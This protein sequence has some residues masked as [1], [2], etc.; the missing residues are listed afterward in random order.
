MSTSAEQ[1]PPFEEL[2][3]ED[4]VVADWRFDQFRSLGFGDEDASLLE[5][6]GAD[7]HLARSLVGAGC[8]LHLALRIVL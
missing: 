6:A 5:G 3:L 7:L 4:R 8:P 2:E 1:H